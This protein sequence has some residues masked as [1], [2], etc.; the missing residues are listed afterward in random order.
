MCRLFFVYEEVPRLLGISSNTCDWTEYPEWTN[1]STLIVMVWVLFFPSLHLYI[2][3]SYLE[4]D[5]K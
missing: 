3:K 4:K 5:S 1:T 2:I